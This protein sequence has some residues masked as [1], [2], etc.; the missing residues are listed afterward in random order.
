M[1]NSRLNKPSRRRTAASLLA[2]AAAT[3]LTFT[4][5]QASEQVEDFA[6]GSQPTEIVLPAPQ[7][8]MGDGLELNPTDRP[9]R[10]TISANDG[11]VLLGEVPVTV[12]PDDRLRIST[13]RI[14]DLLAESV[15]A[16]RLQAIS[17]ALLAR[18][19]ISLD[20]F[21]RSGIG[22]R[23]DPRSLTLQFL[24]PS[25][26]R[27][28]R[29][30]QVS[31]LDR[32]RVGDFLQPENFSAYLNIRG[33][34]DYV[35]DGP[36]TGFQ[37]PTFFLDGA[38]RIGDVVIEGEA[39]WQPGAN[40]A[41]DF[42]R[43]G[44]RIVYDDLD[45]L[46]RLTAGDL[47]PVARA[48]QVTPNIAGLSLARSYSEL[49]PQQII[50]PR[51][52]RSF[53][54]E[55]AATVEVYVNGSLARRVRLNP[56]NYNLNDF[57]YTQGAN[58][59]RINIIDD[60][61]RQETLRFNIFLDQTQLA[62]GL[63]EFGVYAGVQAPLGPTGPDY[64][65]DLVF[66][67]FVRH[68]IS[69]QLTLG[70]NLQLD[71]NSAMG[72]VEAVFGTAIGTFSSN[73]AASHVDNVGEGW[74][75][76]VSFQRLFQRPQGYADSL[77]VFVETRSKKFA[78]I[79]FFL[80]VNPYEVELGGGY[81]HA[82]NERAYVGVDG[83]FSKGRNGFAD[84]HS[85]RLSS[86][87][88]VNDRISFTA[89]ARYEKN[90]FRDEVSG[91]V[92]LN[93]RLG[94][95][96][97]ARVQFDSRDNRARASF[98]T[99]TGQGVGSFNLSADIERSDFGSGFNF[100]GNY[101]SNVG[102]FGLSHFGD[103]AGDFGQSRSQRST[104][105]MASSIAFAGDS[106]AIGRPIYDSFAIVKPHEKLKGEKILIDP[107]VA[108]YVAD[109]ATFGAG[110]HPSLNSYSERT[111]AV[112]APESSAGTDLGTGTFRVLPQ[113]RSGYKMIV[114]SEYSMTAIGTL[115]NPEG[116]PVSLAIGKITEV[117]KDNPMSYEIFTNREGRF[118]IPGL[119][120]GKW[121]LEMLDD[122][123]SSAEITIPDN[124]E[125]NIVR[126]GPIRTSGRQ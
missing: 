73:L 66:T 59:I 10:L 82:I 68:G 81:S 71:E 64:S 104:L 46:F 36:S 123:R 40:G 67:G 80:P 49:R 122:D 106:L 78:P 76:T 1:R 31:A 96:S 83:R 69:D 9:I 37:E 88:R 74:A 47:Q 55:R 14:L 87:Y 48:F 118:G 105:R 57:P 30:L 32:G 120:P 44:T 100:N 21:E 112:E 19:E 16:D 63:T 102:E 52:N 6:G 86:G 43:Q 58:D 124:P 45:N 75:G 95:F 89:E 56:G 116:E 13:R 93:I 92:S 17:G 18:R 51:G 111:V 25:E 77:N 107:S 65:N 103:F 2:I 41:A 15:D 110:V 11:P 53:L 33:A 42:Q 22:L 27:A 113:Y 3:C 50:R 28:S 8:S 79:S 35:S 121:R 61:G 91:M 60:S 20:E 72:G 101:Y 39:F 34:L 85:Y 23:F 62:K 99:L 4:P 7:T 98:Q 5:V 115:L 24:I 97:S 109:T 108:G 119:A 126:L 125:V 70:G 114:G 12:M 26:L 117:D 90:L 38:S 84:Q 94:G 29:N 54:L